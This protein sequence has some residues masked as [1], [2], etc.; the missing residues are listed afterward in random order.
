ME[1][2]EKL[3]MFMI[4]TEVDDIGTMAQQQAQS[5]S[6][7]SSSRKPGSATGVTGKEDIG[8]TD[9][10][11]SGTSNQD[12]DGD[13]TPDAIDPDSTDPTGEDIPEDD[14][15][16]DGD[17]TGGDS[18]DGEDDTTSDTD[19]TNMDDDSHGQDPAFDKNK[20]KDN[21]ILFHG[22]ITSN[23]NLL[24]DCMRQITDPD[25]VTL[26]N[27]VIDNFQNCKTMCYDMITKTDFAQVPYTDLLRKYVALNRVHELG[28]KMIKLHADEHTKKN[29]KSGK[30]PSRKK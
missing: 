19:P 7:K 8:D 21:L 30:G 12:N 27:N 16:S 15:S 13:G 24:R 5:M 18:E 23:I 9:I 22:I 29:L 6:G 20:I 3:A 28:I 25:M 1:I 2:A 17:I 4:A 14:E 11:H 10:I 26:Y